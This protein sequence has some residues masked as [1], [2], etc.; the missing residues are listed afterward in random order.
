MTP[1]ERPLALFGREAS[2]VVADLL[3]S[4]R[5]EFVGGVHADVEHGAVLAGAR[6]ID[7][8]RTVTLPVPV[9]PRIPGLPAD[10]DGFLP[11]DPHGLVWG[12]QDVFAAGD[13]TGSPVK[14]G[15]LAAQQAVAA[16]EAIAARHGVDIDPEPFRPVVRGM[17]LTGGRPRWLRSEPGASSASPQALWWPPTKIA[18]RY[19]APYLV[20][21]DGAEELRRPPA[22]ARP[23]QRELD[24]DPAPHGREDAKR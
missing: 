6:R 1:E 4:E 11:V 2:A 14:Q 15:G 5:I 16:A 10:A 19:L 20:G 24:L 13:V 23:V 3:V 21:G 18:T 12:V 7:V 9:G 22:G 17:L 8:D